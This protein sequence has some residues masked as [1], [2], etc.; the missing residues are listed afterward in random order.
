MAVIIG[1]ILCGSGLF[2]VFH[3]NGSTGGTDVIVSIFNKYTTLSL[4]RAMIL[5][6]AT[7]VITSYFVNVYVS[8]K[9]PQLG[10]ELLTF[11]I[12]EVVF[13]AITLDYWTNSNKH[14]IQLFIFSKKYK[15]I[16][17]AII[18]RLHRGCTLIH[19]DGGYSQEEMRILWWSPARLI[20]RASIVSSRRSI[21][22]RSSPR[23]RCMGSTVEAS[24]I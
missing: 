23:V 15:E 6:D 24:T 10:A 16:N 1:G 17:E 4:G 19:A 21:P 5:I 3:V 22:T 18:Q 12:V 13:C 8:G 20:Y 7:I 2:L 11:S 14:S 9:D